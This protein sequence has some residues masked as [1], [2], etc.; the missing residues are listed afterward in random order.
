MNF[1]IHFRD[2]NSFEL[3][4][5]A[6]TCLPGILFTDQ[7]RSTNTSPVLYQKALTQDLC[8]TITCNLHVMQRVILSIHLENVLRHTFLWSVV[9]HLSDEINALDKFLFDTSQFDLLNI[10]MGS[11]LSLS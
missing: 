7:P 4:L 11:Y 10:K 5:V 9:F 2:K 8:N 6:F 1:D 3:D